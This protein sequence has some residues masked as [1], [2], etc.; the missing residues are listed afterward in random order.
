MKPLT[1]L[2]FPALALCRGI[3]VGPSV[4]KITKEWNDVFP[5]RNF[6]RN[7][8]VP[9]WETGLLPD[10]VYSELE[11]D[12]ETIANASCVV[13]DDAFYKAPNHTVPKTVEDIF[14]FPPPPSYAQRQ[15]HDGTVYVPETNSIFVAELFSPKPGY[16]MKAIPYVW[17]IDISNHSAPVTQKVYP[18]PPL[19]IANGATYFNGYV[20]WA[21]EGNYTT[22]S[23]IVRMDPV[24]LETEVVKNNFYGHRFN[25]LNDLVITRD[26]IAFF[27]D[28]YYGYAN[29]NDTLF[30]ELANG[31]YRWDMHTGNIKMVAGAAEG[32]FFNPNGV[33][34]SSDHTKLFVTNRGETSADPHGGRTIYAHD[35]LDHGIS[36]REILAY[37]DAGFPDGIKTDREG[38]VYGAVVGGVDVFDAA[39]TLLGRIKVDADDVAVNMAWAGKWLYIF[40]RNKIYRVELETEEV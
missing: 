16:G 6:N 23:A 36:N 15:I 37:V 12:L 29:F 11:E 13:Y 35:I 40:G 17:K 24:T 20:Y 2:F 26:G 22:P 27:T 10:P 31:V 8:T 1:L 39:G 19:T 30:P 33:A 14:T 3:L 38:R 4:V 28:G 32:A 18:N 21:Q 7:V 5:Y 34:L 9:F 25:S